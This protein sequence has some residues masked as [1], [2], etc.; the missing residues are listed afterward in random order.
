MDK[1]YK[2]FMIELSNKHTQNLSK[3]KNFKLRKNNMHKL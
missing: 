3:T 1:P 2:N